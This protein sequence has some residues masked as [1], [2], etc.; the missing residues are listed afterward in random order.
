MELRVLQYFIT[1]AA[2]GNITKASQILHM[3][4]PT[5]SKQLRDL[6]D[7]L[8]IQL[9]D[10]GN[11]G[12]TLTP[13]GEYFLGK[14]KDIIS[15]L[16]GTLANLRTQDTLTGELH[17][18]TNESPKLKELT[19]IF[20]EIEKDHPDTQ[21]HLHGLRMEDAFEQLDKGLLDFVLSVG[22]VK[23]ERYEH[24]RLPWMDQAAIILPKD[25]PLAQKDTIKASDLEGLPLIVFGQKEAYHDLSNWFGKSIDQLHIVGSFNIPSIGIQMTL[26]GLGL[27]FSLSDL[28][29]PEE[30]VSRPLKPL[31]TPALRLIW[32]KDH[33]LSDLAQAFLQRI[34][35][36][37]TM[38]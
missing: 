21:L 8:G 12:M 18:G 28:P 5:L 7:E 30:L 9:F 13:G 24:I 16:D 3:S 27:A 20:A 33:T 10:R 1:I 26:S 37:P 38:D 32:K 14:V 6:E 36:L 35:D 4:Q 2:E 15:L 34:K 25:H 23:T 22:L 29:L 11:R 19:A 31:A 17:I